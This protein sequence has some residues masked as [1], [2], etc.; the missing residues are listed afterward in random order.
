[1]QTPPILYQ[2]TKIYLHC[3][4][5]IKYTRNKKCIG[6]GS[7]GKINLQGASEGK[8]KLTRERERKTGGK[9]V[10]CEWWW[11]TEMEGWACERKIE[12]HSVG[13]AV[14][15]GVISARGRQFGTVSDE[16]VMWQQVWMWVAFE[17]SGQEEEGFWHGE[18]EDWRLEIGGLRG[19]GDI[20]M[21]IVEF[22]GWWR[23]ERGCL[24]G[25]GMV[26]WGWG[27]EM[28]RGEEKK[29]PKA[30]FSCLNPTPNQKKKKGLF[31]LMP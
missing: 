25:R 2:T 3:Y 19:K 28:K 10:E 12:T 1:M 14:R 15:W 23:M 31:T 22:G 5:V 29:D 26:A 21:E 17:V 7:E 13:E 4:L 8:T 11:R 6:G 16:V 30:S 20:G 18:Q 27:Y 24:G 9:W